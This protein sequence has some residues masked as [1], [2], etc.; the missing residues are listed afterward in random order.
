MLDPVA[1]EANYHADKEEADVGVGEMQATFNPANAQGSFQTGS[2]PTG[3]E[4]SALMV[5]LSQPGLRGQAH[6]PS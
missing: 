4:V 3:Q 1:E 2:P 5:S 6:R